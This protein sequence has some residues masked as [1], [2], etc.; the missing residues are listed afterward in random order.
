MDNLRDDDAFYWTEMKNLQENKSNIPHI[1][2]YN[3]HSTIGMPC[4]TFKFDIAVELWEEE[5]PGVMFGMFGMLWTAQHH[6]V[7]HWTV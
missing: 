3:Y 1:F 5:S 7:P 4:R 2:T 6:P